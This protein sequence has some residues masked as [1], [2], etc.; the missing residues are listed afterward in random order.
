MP[1]YIWLLH[2]LANKR[3]HRNGSLRYLSP[4]GEAQAVR[5]Q[6]CIGARKISMRLTIFFLSTFSTFISISFLVTY[7]VEA[8]APSEIQSLI[9]QWTTLNKK[10][11][12]GSGNSADTWKACESRKKVYGEIVSKG[13]CYGRKGEY[14]YQHHWHQ[15]N[16]D[17]IRK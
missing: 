4:S 16:Q 8:Q 7:P 10:C 6:S 13:W 3:L 1:R 11:R 12:G 2:K 5:R 14:G 9:N 17:S 15:C